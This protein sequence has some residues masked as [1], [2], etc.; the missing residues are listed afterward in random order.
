MGKGVINTRPKWCKACGICMTFCPQ[1][2]LGMDK[3]SGKVCV[4][5]ADKCNGC[6]LC[7]LR[8]PDFAIDVDN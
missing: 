7:E 2:V 4:V 8:C 1:Q 6:R 3:D 5:N